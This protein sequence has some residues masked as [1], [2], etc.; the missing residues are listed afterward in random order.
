MQGLKRLAYRHWVLAVICLM[1][2]ITYLDN[3][4]RGYGLERRLSS[5]AMD[6]LMRYE[7]PGNI[8]ELRNLVENMVVSSPGPVISAAD[9]PLPVAA[10][11]MRLGNR[12]TTERLEAA[13]QR[14]V[15]IGACSLRSVQPI[16]ECGLGRIP[17]ESEPGSPAP[18]TAH[19]NVRGPEYHR[20]PWLAPLAGVHTSCT[21]YIGHWGA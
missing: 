15:A 16:L 3:F 9:L 13:A 19:A 7:W 1:Y 12:Y 11:L 6:R 21:G 18:I 5:A 4:C 14:A 20:S 8:R 2:F 17:P 10:G